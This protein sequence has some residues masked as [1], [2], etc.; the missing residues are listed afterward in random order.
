MGMPQRIW[1]KYERMTQGGVLAIQDQDITQITL[2]RI[3]DSQ[4]YDLYMQHTCIN[5]ESG[6]MEMTLEFV[7]RF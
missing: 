3:F 2:M 7:K 6:M 4:G 5:Q 1:V